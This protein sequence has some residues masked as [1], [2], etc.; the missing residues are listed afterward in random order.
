MHIEGKIA[1][2]KS[3]VQLLKKSNVI[4]RFEYVIE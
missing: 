4:P 3:A 1:K 2:K